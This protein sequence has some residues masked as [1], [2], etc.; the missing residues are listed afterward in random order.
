MAREKV[1][2]VV[3]SVGLLVA[4]GC[5]N[6]GPSVA[7]RSPRANLPRD[8]VVVLDK[9]VTDTSGWIPWEKQSKIVVEENRKGTTATGLLKVD[10]TIRNRTDH[11]LRL[12]VKTR[13][14]ASSG[15]QVDETA[16]ETLILRPQ[17]T[18]PYSSSSLKEAA[19]YR[20]EI[21]TAK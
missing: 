1:L 6:E 11:V 16:R 21:G 9:S 18:R 7:I 2:A 20:V 10:I 19:E 13:F 3:L 14:F 12:D 4:A 17:E 5:Q 15:L 8:S